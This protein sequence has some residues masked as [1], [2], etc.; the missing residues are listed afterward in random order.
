MCHVCLCL[1]S[2]SPGNKTPGARPCPHQD[3]LG[4]GLHAGDARHEAHLY[5][6]HPGTPYSAQL[7][8]TGQIGV[9][10]SSATVFFSSPG[11]RKKS[12]RVQKCFCSLAFLAPCFMLAPPPGLVCRSPLTLPLSRPAL[13][14]PSLFL[15]PVSHSNSRTL[16]LCCRFPTVVDVMGLLRSRGGPVPPTPVPPTAHTGGAPAGGND[17]GKD[18][19]GARHPG[20]WRRGGGPRVRV[21]E[22]RRSFHAR[23]HL[24]QARVSGACA[25]GRGRGRGHFPSYVLQVR[26]AV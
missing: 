7:N 12:S 14:R 10:F 23:H 26:G 17:H 13:R 19:G 25:G 16:S 4:G 24:Q 9:S 3:G 15:S 18:G 20:R 8:P 11:T 1:G 22:G 21:E 6:N 5:A 2:P